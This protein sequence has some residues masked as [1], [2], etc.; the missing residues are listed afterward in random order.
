M[1]RLAVALACATAALVFAAA[2]LP[3]IYAG[4]KQ[5][6]PG[7]GAGT[8]YSWS[9]LHNYFSTYGCCGDKAVTFIDNVRYAWHNTVRNSAQTTTTY[10]PSPKP[11][12]MKGHCV[13]YSYFWGS[14]SI[15]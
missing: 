12:A 4:P 7:A 6:T 11:A 1:R 10:P 5:W 3:G 2:A 8:P 9:W 13:A 15:G 14:C